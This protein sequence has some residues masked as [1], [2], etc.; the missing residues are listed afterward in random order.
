MRRLS[1]RN[2]FPNNGRTPKQ[3]YRFASTAPFHNRP[4]SNSHTSIG[5][6]VAQRRTLQ[7][8]RVVAHHRYVPTRHGA[9]NEYFSKQTRF[10]IL[11]TDRHRHFCSRCICKSNI[12]VETSLTTETTKMHSDYRLQLARQPFESQ[13]LKR[14]GGKNPTQSN[15]ADTAATKAN[16][17]YVE[18]SEWRR[19]AHRDAPQAA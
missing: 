17:A 9:I 10:A 11:L 13:I 8:L 2:G 12:I 14:Q 15:E 16:K 6:D 1:M 4:R 3:I 18:A 19:A 5:V 7:S